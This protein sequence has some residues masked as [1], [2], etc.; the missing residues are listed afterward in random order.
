MC[1]FAHVRG[2]RNRE[3]LNV[4][5]LKKLVTPC[6]KLIVNILKLSVYSPDQKI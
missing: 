4:Y 2:K 3:K 5:I 1:R 6:N